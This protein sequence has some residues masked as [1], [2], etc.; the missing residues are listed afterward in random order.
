MSRRHPLV[1]DGKKK[2]GENKAALVAVL[3]EISFVF[4]S[5]EYIYTSISPGKQREILQ[6]NSVNTE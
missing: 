2:T 1:G 5:P 3:L 4:F 6:L